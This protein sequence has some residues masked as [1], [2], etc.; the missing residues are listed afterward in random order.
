MTTANAIRDLI[1]SGLEDTTLADRVLAI[2]KAF[3]GKP[4]TK[5][6]ATAVQKALPERTVHY[7]TIGSMV[8]L[9]IWGAGTEHKNRSSFLLGYTDTSRFGPASTLNAHNY[10]IEH[11]ARYYSAAR[12]RNAKRRALMADETWC[13]KV[14]LTINALNSERA[15]YESLV[16]WDNPA[17]FA[18]KNL[19]EEVV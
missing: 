7:S 4:I 18:L 2:L 12:E 19:I 9:E 13:L 15:T 17:R 11:N 10:E 14:A 6:L 5:R 1:A 8:H 16:E 3:D